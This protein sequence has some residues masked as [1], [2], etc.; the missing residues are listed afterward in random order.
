MKESNMSQTDHETNLFEELKNDIRCE[1]DHALRYWQQIRKR[2]VYEGLQYSA[3][4]VFE[5]FMSA[6]FQ[7]VEAI[8]QK[9][10]IDWQTIGNDVRRMADLLE[11][12]KC[13]EELFPK[14]NESFVGDSEI[15][16]KQ[17]IIEDIDQCYFYHTI[18]LPGH[19]T[20][21]GTWDLRNG[22]NNYLGGFNFR[23]KRVLDVGTAN[24]MLCFEIERQGGEV[25]AFDLSKDNRWDLVPY[26]RWKEFESTFPGHAKHID[27]LN[28][29]FWF[30]H[31]CVNSNAKVVYGN[32]Y[33]IPEQIGKVDV[34]IYGAILL[35]LRDPFLALQSGT[36]LTQDTVVVTEFLRPQ[37]FESKKGVDQNFKEPCLTFLPDPETL[38][39]KDTWWDLKPEIIVRMLK[40]LGFAD[41][42]VTYHS[43]LYEGE[44]AQLYTVVGRKGN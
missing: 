38:E 18:D 33:N 12:L 20:I 2:Y 21:E 22:I 24:G 29:A 13:E 27:K 5:W 19:G 16:A 4:D 42:N 30:C 31:R 15:Y 36:K 44:V 35:H 43:Q 23:G 3:Q 6:P 26:A 14:T 41:M 25:V 1:R 9:L 11:G 37:T 40:V 28:N 10:G 17:R 39:P 7:E 8:S 34:V 32:V